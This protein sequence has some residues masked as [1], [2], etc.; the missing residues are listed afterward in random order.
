MA[1]GRKRV[2]R[3]GWRHLPT[4]PPGASCPLIPPRAGPFAESLLTA[5]LARPCKGLSQCH[6]RFAIVTRVHDTHTCTPNTHTSRTRTPAP[7]SRATCSKEEQKKSQRTKSACGHRAAGH[8]PSRP[9][10]GLSPHTWEAPLPRCTSL[11]RPPPGPRARRPSRPGTRP[12]APPP[13]P[14]GRP[15]RSLPA[16]APLTEPGVGSGLGSPPAGTLEGDASPRR[17]RFAGGA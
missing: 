15:R 1:G 4:V 3:G 10:Q 13:D 14:T 2:V 11:R 8:W 5:A 6:A 9:V 7:T 17:W 12:A 16:R